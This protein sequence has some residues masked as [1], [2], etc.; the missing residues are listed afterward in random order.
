MGFESEQQA[1][2]IT[3]RSM[4]IDMNVE[5]L[6]TLAQMQ[7]SLDGTLEVEFASGCELLRC[8]GEAGV[9]QCCVTCFVL[10]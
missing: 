9:V 3:I 10:L 4:A 7:A 2:L 5:Q 1:G 8:R 6:H